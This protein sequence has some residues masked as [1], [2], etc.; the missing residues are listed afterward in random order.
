MNT[1]EP[2]LLRVE[3]VADLPVL[4]ATLQRLD[5][6]ATLDRL[7]PTPAHWKGPLSPG[8]VL[9]VWL[10]FLLSQGDHCLN[11]VEPWVAQH[12][13][14]LS[15][16]LGKTVLPVH[17]HDDRLADWLD[18]LCS[19]DSFATLEQQL[20]QHTIRVYQLPT[21]TIR[22]DTTTANSYADVLSEQGLL[23]FGHSKDDPTRPQLKIACGVLDPLGMPL[24][25]AV[26]PGN[27][28]DD[29]LYIPA[30]ATVQQSIGQ[31][32]RTHVGDC[33]MAA[34]ATRAFVAAGQD[35]YLCPLSEN[36]LSRAQ[37]RALLQPVFA[38]TQALEQVWRPTGDGQ[39]DELVTEGFCVD[40]ELTAVVGDKQVSWSERRWVVRSLAYAQA[41]QAALE[42]RLEK[43]S[44]AL[45]ELVVRKQGKKQLCH[46]ELMEAAGA[47]V[48]RDGVQGLLSYTAQAM[49][50]T[51][52]VRGYR[53][54]PA[55]QETDVFFE[56]DVRREEALIEEKK[57]EMGWQVYAT[58]AL[59]MVLAQVVWA[60]RGQYR[61]ENDWS[62]LKGRPLGLTPMYLQDEQRMQG[63]VY[64]LSLALR[65]LTLLEWVVRERLREEGAKL[66]GIYAGQPG[67]KTDRPSAEL[68]LG[69][70][71]TISVS[72]VVVN[73]QTHALLSPLTDVQRRLLE[74]WHLPSDLYEKLVRGFPIPPPNTS[75]P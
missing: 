11:H 35:F 24:V 18:R 43:A 23:Q 31:G 52:R 55:R 51:R 49:M 53:G 70:M 4:W 10:L 58:N 64:L 40:V 50:T 25:T 19:D 75:E 38:G 44:K 6:P 2:R 65:L 28:T 5:L 20:N 56:I 66:Q 16:L 69:V 9:S 62:R 68:L 39:P 45:R 41:Q 1:S 74:L 63:L 26:V 3:V 59:A 29:P 47:I 13:G 54:R 15:A 14:I 8:E 48:Q 61:I 37:R 72:V 67:R 27:S 17:C 60:Y 46:D 7:F 71:K 21:D 42:R 57:R 32:G 22:Y 36:Q 73:G 34:L 33:K 30:I 12:H